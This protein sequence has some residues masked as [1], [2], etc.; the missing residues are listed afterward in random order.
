MLVASTTII[1]KNKP[2]LNLLTITYFMHCT[3]IPYCFFT[4]KKQLKQRLYKMKF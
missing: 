1:D 4:K 2:L 3:G